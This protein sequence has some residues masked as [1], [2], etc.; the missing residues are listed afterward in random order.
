[1]GPGFWLDIFNG[2]GL[3]DFEGVFIGK[4][5]GEVIRRSD[6]FLVWRSAKRCLSVHQTDLGSV[7]VWIECFGRPGGQQVVQRCLNQ[8]CCLI[9]TKRTVLKDEIDCWMQT[10]N[11]SKQKRPIAMRVQSGIPA[12]CMAMAPPERRECVP[13]SSGENPGL[14]APTLMVVRKCL[15]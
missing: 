15:I 6:G 10:I 7:D 3:S 5:D 13:T 9:F 4:C 1:M 2:L 8:G 14:A 12:V 11:P